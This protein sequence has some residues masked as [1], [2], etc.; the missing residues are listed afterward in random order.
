L[1][2]QLVI[3]PP[4]P[5]PI[6]DPPSLVPEVEDVAASVADVEAMAARIIDRATIVKQARV[7]IGV[8]EFVAF[9]CARRR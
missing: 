5:P 7:C 3:P 8:F 4:L 9:C 6:D 2:D 1:A